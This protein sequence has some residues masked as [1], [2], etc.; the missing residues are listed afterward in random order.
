CPEKITAVGEGA[1]PKQEG[2]DGG[3]TVRKEEG[4]RHRLSNVN[5][6]NMGR[7]QK[8]KCVVDN[9]VAVDIGANQ[10]GDIATVALLEETDQLLGKDHLFKRSLLLIKSWWVY[11]SRAYTGSNMLSRITESA[12]ATMVLAVVN[13][14]HARLHTPLQVMA[15]FFHMHSHFDWSRYC[16]CIEGPRR[17][18]T[19]HTNSN[20]ASATAADLALNS[21]HGEGS[22]AAA[23][24]GEGEGEGCGSVVAVGGLA[25]G[26]APLL[27]SQEVL[28]RYRLRQTGR[29][30]NHGGSTGGGGAQRHHHQQTAGSGG[31]KSPQIGGTGAQATGEPG[32]W[33]TGAAGVASVPGADGGKED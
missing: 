21:N 17:L 9:Q 11:E 12:L 22:T 31:R 14:H 24:I 3:A 8:I 30:R 6:I 13:Q 20:S 7:V 10:V 4:Y 33:M 2:E 5:F 19:L 23:V 1:T 16:W 27:L 32:E 15:L 28:N 18:D 26:P 29:G 25:E